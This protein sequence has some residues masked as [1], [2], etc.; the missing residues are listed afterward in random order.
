MVSGGQKQRITI[1]RAILKNTPILLLDEATAA[2]DSQSESDVHGAFDELIKGRTTIIV[3]H[4]LS[5]VQNADRII[6]IENGVN[7]AIY[8]LVDR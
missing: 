4:R 5:T 6:V 2:L 7:K 8:F 3:A 1:A